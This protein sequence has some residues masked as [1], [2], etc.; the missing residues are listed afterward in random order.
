MAKHNA[1]L[2]DE[3]SLSSYVSQIRKIPLLGEDE[4]FELARKWHKRGDKKAL[5]KL[6]SSHLRLVNK[7]ANGYSGYGLPKEDLISEGHL[8][9]MHAIEHFD[10]E[11]GYKFSTYA[12]WWVKA[13]IKDFIFNSWSLVKLGSKKDTRK[14]FFSL[15]KIKASLGIDS[16]SDEDA[17]KISK[18]INVD[19]NDILRIEKRLT[20]KDFSTN[21]SMGDED[22]RSWQDFI[23]DENAN[24]EKDIL[25]KNE[26]EYRKKMLH[27][28]LNTLSKREYE[29]VCA[30]R[31]HSPTKTLQQIAKTLNISA[32]RVRQIDIA[33]ML[34]IQKYIKS[35]E[36]NKKHEHA[37]L[38]I[39]FIIMMPIKL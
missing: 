5:N 29:I 20:Q 38:V 34:K 1:N 2:R 35:A 27:E 31:L 33:A 23:A 36:W 22:T 39:L 3:S 8:G 9:L 37:D 26:Y 4:E 7:I 24:H 32:E 12:I 10:P 21:T 6:I 18:Q 13:K 11:I 28:A 25:E 15:N 19:K 14:L 17:Q 30:Y 16:I